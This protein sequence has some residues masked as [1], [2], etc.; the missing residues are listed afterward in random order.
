MDKKVSPLYFEKRYEIG[1]MELDCFN[2]CRASSLLGYLQDAAGLA[3]AEYGATNMEMVQKYGHCWM[4]VRTAFT[5]SRPLRWGDVLTVKTWHRGGE[6]PL[7]YRDFDLSVDGQSVGQALS[8]WVLVD[9]NTHTVTRADHFP[10]FAGTDGGDLIRD[11]KLPK[12]RLPQGMAPVQRRDL[13]Y[14]ETDGN[15]H[16]NNTRYADFL[17]DALELH[18][19]GE[20]TFVREFYISYSQECRAGE[21]LEL[22]V[23]QDGPRRHVLGQDAAGTH[24]FHGYAVTGESFP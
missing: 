18:R 6:K 12:L 8:I 23:G 17:C 4:V 13:Y 16:V 11:T 2:H 22:L 5:L 7:M 19:A 14:S 20:G 10:E 9:L 15:G 1:T 21:T 24:R 3:A